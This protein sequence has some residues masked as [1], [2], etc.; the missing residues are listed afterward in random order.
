MNTQI[1]PPLSSRLRRNAR[2][3]WAIAWKDIVE[4]LKN[5]NTLAV[6]LTALP[7]IF[8]YYYLPIL[9]TRG[10]PPFVR[11]YD[12]GNSVLVARLENSEVLDVRT[13]PSEEIMKRALTKADIPELGLVI[14][15]GFDQAVSTGGEAQLQGYVLNWV[16]P[17]DAQELLSL[18]EDEVAFQLG[19]PVA[20]VLQERVYLA[21]DSTGVS[22]SAGISLVYVVTMVGLLLIPHLILEEKKTR[23]MDMLMVSP[24]N[25]NN[26]VA[27]KAIAGLFYCLLGAS[28]ALVFYRWLYIHWWLAVL[29]T[30][31]GAL[32]VISIGL[33]L[34]SLIE[35]REQLTMIAWIFI[36]PLF[37]PVF[38]ILMRGLIPDTV[39]NVLR[40]VPTVVYLNLLRASAAAAF[41]ASTVLLQLAWLVAW[42]V[43]V[44]LLVG[45]LVRRQDRQ[46]A[47]SVPATYMEETSSFPLL[48]AATRWLASLT[49]RSPRT[50]MVAEAAV[51]ESEM[52]VGGGG[53]DL[54]AGNRDAWRIIWA[55]ASKDILAT[56]KSKLALSIMMGTAILL[57]SNK[58]LP[59]LLRSRNAPAAIVYDQ[60]R[61]TIL[62]GLAA[63]D[64]LR[65]GITDSLEE[66]Q[67]TVT[68]SPEIFLGLVVPE[69]FDQQAGSA[70][71][72]ELEAFV[73]HWA[74]PETVSQR[75]AF[76]EEQLGQSTW[77]QVH[78]QLA[79]QSLYPPA[80]PEGQS[81]MSM[82]SFSIILFTMGIALVP[83]L[84]VEER[85]AHTLDMLL[86]S[87]ARISEV[88]IG[89]ALAGA[90]YCLLAAVVLFLFNAYLIVHWG[91]ALLTVVLGAALAVAIGLLVGIISDSPTTASMWGGLILLLVVA[92]TV[93]AILPGINWLPAVDNLLDY[94][95]TS[96]LVEMLGYSLAGEIPLLQVW[97]NAA[98]LLVGVLIVLGLV[99]WRLRLADR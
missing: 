31:L 29:S 14:P 61:S 19:Q 42:A 17:E 89:K 18:I 86:V 64:D 73:V 94:L 96:A 60:G 91:L 53:D 48:E 87:P 79:E 80:K 9:G 10:E 36:L 34:G 50:A 83:L 5:K 70:Q 3:I 39:I 2:I 37:L 98:A 45:W 20:I 88:V 82:L 52:F 71:V 58:A 99:G 8:V 85:Q 59:L 97:T 56:L 33:L 84:F 72:I 4:A 26:L 11:V 62:R 95:P 13:Y 65:L 49:K 32:F 23:T 46:P 27:G 75:V 92:L 41:S 44:M 69:D 51:V 78:I 22:T 68:S 90:F 25:P 74:D 54:P 6:L 81:A 38:L 93:M 16:R 63:S 77:G 21:P 76:F 40:F 24:A 28:I 1:K 57:L 35:S 67:K 7:M 47:R 55:I 12:A 15:Q 30:V 66:M 43:G